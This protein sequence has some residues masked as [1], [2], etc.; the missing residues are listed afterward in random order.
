M[1]GGLREL[2]RPTWQAI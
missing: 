2:H 1:K